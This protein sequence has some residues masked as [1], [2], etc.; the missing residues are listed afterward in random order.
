MSWLIYAFRWAGSWP[1]APLVA[2]LRPGASA[3]APGRAKLPP[4]RFPALLGLQ[5]P[6]RGWHRVPAVLEIV[7]VLVDLLLPVGRIAAS[8]LPGGYPGQ[9][10]SCRKLPASTGGL[11]RDLGEGASDDY[12]PFANKEFVHDTLC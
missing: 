10:W 5:R 8:G 9:L 6:E 4:G 11:Q 12:S 1:A 2:S 3:A 7:G